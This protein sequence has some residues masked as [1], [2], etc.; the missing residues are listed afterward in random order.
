MK[1]IMSIVLVTMAF[2]TGRQTQ[3]AESDQQ[4]KCFLVFDPMTKVQRDLDY[5]VTIIMYARSA[6]ADIHAT[7]NG[8]K[9]DVKSQGSQFMPVLKWFRGASEGK[10]MDIVG[11]VSDGIDN[12]ECKITVSVNEQACDSGER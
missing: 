3:A 4:L 12:A 2:F 6:N 11:K 5:A 1:R 7:L 10:T 9:L 8:E